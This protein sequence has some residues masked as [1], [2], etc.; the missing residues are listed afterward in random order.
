MQGSMLNVAWNT[1]RRQVG[2]ALRTHPEIRDH[3]A[4]AETW[5]LQQHHTLS[6]VFPALIRPRPYLVM[7]AV[8]GYCNLRCMVSRAGHEKAPA[9]N[10][11]VRAGALYYLAVRRSGDLLD[12]GDQPAPVAA[13]RLG[14]MPDLVDDFG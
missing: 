2:V 8:T 4:H 9:P 11:A 14:E 7:I 1:V 13:A 6:R 5:V 12:A 3:A 10:L